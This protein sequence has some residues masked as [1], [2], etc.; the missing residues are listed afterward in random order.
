MF[1]ILLAG[2][3][4]WDVTHKAFSEPDDDYEEP[5]FS[6]HKFRP[7]ISLQSSYSDDDTYDEP[8]FV[9]PRFHPRPSRHKA[10]YSDDDT[11]EEPSFSRLRFRPRLSSQDD[12]SDDD[13]DDEPDVSGPRFRPRRPIHSAF[14]EDEYNYDE[15]RPVRARFR[16]RLIYYRHRHR[17]PRPSIYSGYRRYDQATH[18]WPSSSQGYQRSSLMPLPAHAPYGARSFGWTTHPIMQQAWWQPPPFSLTAYPPPN[19][20]VAQLARAGIIGNYRRSM[21]SIPR[22]PSGAFFIPPNPRN[23]SPA[24]QASYLQNLGVETAGTL[25][26]IESTLDKFL[27]FYHTSAVPPTVET[28]GSFFRSLSPLQQEVPEPILTS[29]RGLNIQ[30]RARMLFSSCFRACGRCCQ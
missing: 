22:G 4:L 21:F 6:R 29:L 8:T 2:K 16:P 19:P 7:R 24:Y 17:F 13:A 27:R 20:F 3:K 1:D 15:P 26:G 12:Y 28:A 14:S 23:F 11:Y 5:S 30:R 18:V 10:I 9:R 25:S